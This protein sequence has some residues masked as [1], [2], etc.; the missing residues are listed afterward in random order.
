MGNFEQQMLEFMRRGDSEKVKWMKSLD[1]TILPS[2]VKR[3]IQNDKT[4]LMEMIVPKWVNW[5]LLYDWAQ[6]K[7]TSSGDICI[8]CET[9]S[10]NGINFL[11][12]HVC[13]SCFL[14]LKHLQ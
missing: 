14:K 1:K 12:K 6:N 4:V 9:A 2:Q 11:E 3:I 5:Q 13:E 7:K 10:Q 8:L